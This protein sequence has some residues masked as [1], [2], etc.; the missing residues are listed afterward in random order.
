[1]NEKESLALRQDFPILS[2]PMNGQPLIYLDN[3]AT[4]QMPVQVMD[5]VSSLYRTCNG[6]VHR[7]GHALGRAASEQMEGAREEVRRFLNA[8]HSEEIIF[9]SGT[10]GGVNLLAQIYTG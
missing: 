9:T 7:S 3:A 5:V 2:A 8:E 4:L 1:M 10:T 6:N